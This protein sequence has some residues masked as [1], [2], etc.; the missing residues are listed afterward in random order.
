[1][2]VWGYFFYVHNVFF[3]TGCPV[4]REALGTDYMKAVE[5]A[6]TVLLPAFDEWRTGLQAAA[7]GGSAAGHDAHRGVWIARLGVCRIP[8]RS[9]FYEAGRQDKAQP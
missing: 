4:R 6:E 8:R 9:T 5:R 3:K 7:L 2:G 1:S